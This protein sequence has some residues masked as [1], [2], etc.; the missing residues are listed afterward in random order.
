MPPSAAA[1]SLSP[2][3]HLP[4]FAR[5]TAG[6]SDSREMRRPEEHGKLFASPRRPSLYSRNSPR[7]CSPHSRITHLLS[8][9]FVSSSLRSR[10][11]LPALSVFTRLVSSLLPPRCRCFLRQWDPGHA[12][13]E[14]NAPPRFFF[15]RSLL[16]LM[17]TDCFRFYGNIYT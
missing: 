17:S 3:P 9:V 12:A 14:A 2:L 11:F 1:A 7:P 10:L 16:W 8:G 15:Q 5:N 6:P 4:D 13:P